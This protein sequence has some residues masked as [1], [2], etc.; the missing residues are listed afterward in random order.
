VGEKRARR[1]A[2][3]TSV[4]AIIGRDVFDAEQE[5]LARNKRLAE[6]NGRGQRYLRRAYRFAGGR[7]CR[8]AI[9]ADGQSGQVR[10]GP[11]VG[12]QVSKV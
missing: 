8:K 4:P 7:V 11:T 5:P 2:G 12:A 1:R 6:R 3:E 9:A 10:G